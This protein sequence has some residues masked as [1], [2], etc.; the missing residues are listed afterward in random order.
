M[1][2]PAAAEWQ[3]P[4]WT[5]KSFWP[6]V[7]LPAAAAAECAM[8]QPVSSDQRIRR[9]L[10]IVTA[11]RESEAE[12]DHDPFRTFLG[13][14]H[15]ATNLSHHRRE[16][17]WGPSQCRNYDCLFFKTVNAKRWPRLAVGM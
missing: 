7:G 16:H 2:T 10:V 4:H 14:R 3:A 5:L 12:A 17:Q 9:F 13:S 6:A 15:W 11:P 1:F 8:M